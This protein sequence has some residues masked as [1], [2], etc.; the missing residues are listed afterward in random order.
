[1]A[2]NQFIHCA[3]VTCFICVAALLGGCSPPLPKTWLPSP[4]GA[5]SVDG[6]HVMTASSVT[7]QR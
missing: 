6:W 4:N 7:L 1:M 5:M 3:I 2:G